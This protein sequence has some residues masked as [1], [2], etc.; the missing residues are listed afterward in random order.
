MKKIV[1]FLT[2][3]L[4]PAGA[5]A[6]E[7]W[8]TAESNADGVQAYSFAE[9]GDFFAQSDTMANDSTTRDADEE[10]I[11]DTIDANEPPD[12]EIPNARSATNESR[13]ENIDKA[14]PI[15]QT[16]VASEKTS[17]EKIV[18]GLDTKTDTIQ[19]QNSKILKLYLGIF[20]ALGLLL[21][22]ALA[23]LIWQR[24]ILNRLK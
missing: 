4:L 7:T 12:T 9:A 17:E 10:M 14:T 18:S 5:L 6:S 15:A 13:S 24:K 19:Q 8:A 11:V 22:L 23:G 16:S 2:L 21:L 1:I 20:V 3:V